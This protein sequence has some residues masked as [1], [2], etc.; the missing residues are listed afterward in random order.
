MWTPSLTPRARPAGSVTAASP[1]AV[2]PGPP[3][4]GISATH[5]I[6]AARDANLSPGRRTRTTQTPEPN[7]LGPPTIDERTRQASLHGDVLPLAPKEYQ[8]LALLAADPGA[9]LD[10]RWILETVWEP[11]FFGRGKTLDFHVATLRRKL[12]DPRWIENRR[13]IEFRLIVP[14]G[15]AWPPMDLNSWA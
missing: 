9:V 10:Q 13:G 2:N 5:T 1:V 12:G 8:L 4:P 15:G 3:C 6:V 7:R 14:S 11:N